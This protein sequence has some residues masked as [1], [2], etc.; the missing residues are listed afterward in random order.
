MIEETL[1]FPS[2]N[3]RLEGR[4]T[5]GDQLD[6]PLAFVLICPPHPFMGGDMENNITAGLAHGLAQRDFAV[7]RFNHQGVGRSETCRDL[8]EDQRLFW[9]D[10]TAPAYETQM[11]LDTWAAMA[12]LHQL[13]GTGIRCHVVGYSYGCLSALALVERDPLIDRMVLIAPPL[14]Q[15]PLPPPHPGAGH[16]KALLW[17]ED[18]FACPSPLAKNLF[19]QL[20]A[21]KTRYVLPAGLD[22]FF[23][24][25][26]DHLAAW[27][28]RFLN[29]SEK[30]DP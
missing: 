5:Y 25:Q 20:P 16:P 9:Q 10:S 24:G 26:E 15:W 1:F 13:M 4:L 14:T 22:H 3:L 6:E 28:G 19:D 27:I 8:L 21:P 11:G 29:P 18:D 2:G 23:L 30:N 12:F 7:F 17:A